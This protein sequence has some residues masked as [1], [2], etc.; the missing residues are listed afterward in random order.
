MEDVF[1]KDNAKVFD[2]AEK[3][4]LKGQRYDNSNLYVVNSLSESN[5]AAVM[6][7]KVSQQK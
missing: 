4:V 5:F 1:D 3:Y 7:P 2:T 6:F